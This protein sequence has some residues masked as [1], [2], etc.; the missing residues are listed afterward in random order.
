[1]RTPRSVLVLAVAAGALAVPIALARPDPGPTWAP[2]ASTQVAQ[3]PAEGGPSVR[4]LGIPEADALAEPPSPDLR[5][6]WQRIAAD[7]PAGARRQLARWRAEVPGWTAP[8]EALAELEK[9]E[10]ETA[11]D[12]AVAGGAWGD[13]VA[14]A[15][16]SPRWFAGCDRP[17]LIWPLT[18]ALAALGAEAQLAA[19]Y[20]ALLDACADDVDRLF[21][22]ER[23]L[24]Q[25]PVARAADL[26]ARVDADALD[27]QRRET[28]AGIVQRL[29][30]RQVTAA[31]ADGDPDRAGR[32]A[33]EAEN[34]G[35]A[36][37]LAWRSH[38]AGD[39]ETAAAWFARAIGW[40]TGPAVQDAHFGL[41]V[42]M[43]DRAE[44]DAA[45]RHILALDAADPRRADL[46]ARLDA[47]R[48]AAGEAAPPSPAAGAVA[49]GWAALDAGDAAAARARF[50]RATALGGGNEAR[51][52]A[53]LAAEAT[54]DPAAGLA[55]LAEIA[56]PTPDSR[57]LAVRLHLMEADRALVDGALDR[58]LAQVAAAEAVDAQAAAERAAAIRA[59]V[60]LRQADRAH[61]S[62]DYP[63][64]L[65]LAEGAARHPE[66]AEAARRL[67][68]WAQ[69]QTADFDRAAET[70]AALYDETGSDD[71]AEGL[72][73]SVMAQ[74][75][76]EARLRRRAM[77]E[78]ATGLLATRV[79]QLD[80]R[81]AFDRKDFRHAFEVA[82]ERYPDLAGIAAPWIAQTVGV[83]L[84]GSQAGRDRFDGLVGRTAAGWRRGRDVFVADLRQWAVD[85]GA[86]LPGDPVGNPTAAFA[87]APTDGAVL[88]A[89]RLTWRREGRWS[90]RVS[91]GATPISGE[92]AP[93][94]TAEAGLRF[95]GGGPIVDVAG[96]LRERGDS[97]LSLAGLV[98]PATGRRWGRV[99]EAGA[100]A[101]VAVPVGERLRLTGEALA[102][103]LEGHDTISNDR[104]R[105]GAGLAYDLGIDGFE[106]VAV[107]P[108][109][110]WERYARNSNFHTFG[111]GGY[112]SPQSLH[113]AALTLSFQTEEL[114]PWIA[115]GS[116]AVGPEWIDED[117][118][119]VLPLIG[120]GGR[121]GGASSSGI[122]GS[123]R[124]EVAWRAS[125][126]L[127]VGG[128]VDATV[129]DGYDAVVAGLTLRLT[130]A[131][132]RAVVST[133]LS[134][135]PRELGRR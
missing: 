44:I 37:D 94:P 5:L 43:L 113:R 14:L 42:T 89:P 99:V 90:P 98:D 28:Y 57:A 101:S 4:L 132:R 10:I 117:P 66:T 8:A 83:R 61:Q 6:F 119:D 68:G 46:L 122:A 92:V 73:F 70:F 120:G 1:M 2:P 93:L 86:P 72:F 56:R 103:V 16:A 47:T 87:A 81:Q 45:R 21:V 91:L 105:F 96:F 131:G 38:D 59:V 11:V 35:L 127:I 74:D 108:S 69:Y 18:D 88:V 50:E 100:A 67:I 31:L 23:A 109:W 36:L 15:E 58:A 118:A 80:G 9:L 115:R 63:A 17:D 49:A 29:R 102:S 111:H 134:P 77:A 40:G 65:R 84:D 55:L 114:R 33:L 78:P 64:T 22:L 19:R 62:G 13:L 54:G 85:I 126:T 52:G 123:G 128:F 25:L 112:F 75:G 12:T 116:V 34:A 82:P 130:P 53:A 125:E 27:P 51:Y 76:G 124:L 7:D 95:D 135:D 32:L 24:I 48:P 60:F 41:A 3:A 107:G 133:D 129:S 20:R 71:A 106:Y 121:I 97:L 110:S 104:L 39:L 26:V 79:R 30:A